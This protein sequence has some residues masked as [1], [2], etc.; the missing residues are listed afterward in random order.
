M[1][2]QDNAIAELMRE[3]EVVRRERDEAQRYLDMADVMLL[4]LDA[5]ATVTLV[6]KKGCNILGYR[7]DEIVGKNWI[8]T[9]LPEPVRSQI[10]IDFQ[11]LLADE[12]E[13]LE[14]HVPHPVLCNGGV[15]RIVTFRNTVL[16]DQNGQIIGTLSSGEDVTERVQAEEALRQSEERYRRIVETANE[17]ILWLDTDYRI[18]FVNEKM[19]EIVGSTPEEMIGAPVAKFIFDD[20]VADFNRKTEARRRGESGSYEQRARRKDGSS[21]WLLISAVPAIDS[22]GQF[23]GSFAML[24]DITARKQAE[25]TLRDEREFTRILLENLADGVVACNADGNLVLFNHASRVWHGADA[26]GLPPEE[27]A[28][29]YDLYAEDEK[30]A[31]TIDQIPLARAYHGEH[32]RNVAM[33]IYPR[34]CPPRHVIANGD[35]IFDSAG[36][37]LGAVVVMHDITD[38]KSAEQ[39]LRDSEELYRSLVENINLGISLVDSNYHLRMA[40]SKL[41]AMVESDED[42]LGKPCFQVFENR[43]TACE[44]CPG[45]MAMA[46]GRPADLEL[47]TVLPKGGTRPVR[48]QTFPTFDENHNVTGF[49]EVVED[50]TEQKQHEAQLR[51]AKE[52]AE[53]ANRAKSA[54]L[55][56]MSHEL[57]TPMTAILG[58]TDLLLMPNLPHH[59]QREFLETIQKNGRTLLELINDILDL[60]RIETGSAAVQKAECALRDIVNDVVATAEVRAAEKGLSLQADYSYPLPERIYTDPLRLRQILVNLLGNAVKFTDRG[61]VRM[62]VRCLNEDSGTAR[63]QFTVVDTGIGIAPRAIGELFQPFMQVDSSASRRYGGTGLGLAI[64]KHLAIALGGDIEVASEL[65]RGS[66]F[67]LTI[68][69]GPIE[70][71]RMLQSPAVTPVESEPRSSAR[72]SLHLRGRLLLAEDVPDIQVLVARNL[73]EIGLDVDVADNGRQACDMAMASKTHGSPYDIVLMDIQMP[74]MNGYEAARWLREHDWQGPIVALTAH[75]MVGDREK[76]Q[77]AGCDDYIAKPL[78]ATVLRDVLMRHLQ[79]ANA[80]D[81]IPPERKHD[82]E[83][84]AYLVHTFMMSL[85]A[86]AGSIKE[87]LGQQD[88]HRVAENAHQ[89]KGTAAVYG[90]PTIAQAANTIY[91]QATHDGDLAQ[92]QAAVAE[93]NAF[94]KQ[95]SENAA[96]SCEQRDASEAAIAR[97]REKGWK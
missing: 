77:A 28:R 30:T 24:T 65:D 82:D 76:C 74:G 29:C 96:G 21:C 37:K 52:A 61:E 86:R 92:L 41:V 43:N 9:F 94:C 23:A 51:Q 85:P 3:L 56:N 27:W 97:L 79:V 25:K 34:G 14:Y 87:A 12:L 22:A 45:T 33:C 20:D 13:P 15:E 91:Q 4:A 31:L 7:E 44:F 60:S 1:E 55:A 36:H 62:S 73:R 90:F 63:M 38:R 42:W 50:I 64:S 69:I 26:L 46:S 5:Q 95:A 72:Q 53:A 81:R 6:N 11:R 70:A 48:I 32:V 75:A 80:P 35:P 40:N 2:S 83:S 59:E 93:L 54:F 10:R 19:A 84:V 78:V 66:R 58:F 16:R 89:L 71:T 17:G 57:R 88:I 49:I 8:D 68:D 47:L 39:R 67:T 18:T